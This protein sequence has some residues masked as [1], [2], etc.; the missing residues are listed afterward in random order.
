MWVVHNGI[1]ENHKELRKKLEAAGHTFVSSTDTE[2]LTHLVEE[3]LKTEKD[4]EKAAVAALKEVKGTY[5]V[6]IQYRQDP[7]RI[8][9]ARMGA[10]VVLGLGEHENFIASDASPI[11]RHTRQIVFLE[12]GEVA[13]ITPEGH[14]IRKLEGEL[15]DRV[16]E[17]I[18]WNAEAAQRNGYD[19]F[20]LKEIMEEP[21]AVR[22]TSRG[23]IID[24]D[25][26][27]KLGGLESVAERLRDIRR[28]IIVACGT[29]SYAAMAG[30]YMLEENARIPAEVDI[31]S[32]F[33]YR[34]PVIDEGTAVIAVSQSGET[35][36]T[37]EAVREGKRR[38]AL[39]LGI[40]NTVGSTI[41]RETDAGIYLHAGP[42]IS[43]A[44]TKAYV[45]QLTALALLTLFLGRQRGM[46]VARGK[47]IAQALREL[48]GKIE[49]VLKRSDEIRKVAKKYANTRDFLF[50]G[51]KYN[52]RLHS[53]VHSNSKRHR[54]STPKAAEQGR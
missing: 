29:A 27:A 40:V 28:I 23:R 17:Q 12:D 48:P 20:M 49:E 37:L 22:N 44:S 21:D 16:A 36:D 3:H 10:P 43:V 30:E 7:A 46:S 32:E 1:V 4:F 13:V 39:T 52:L 41:A 34:T 18:D 31:G 14:T 53:K 35:A 50:M 54:T 15:V 19:H 26:L 8:I 2:V 11:L 42:E 25:G 6:A 51:R 5:G 24:S 33:R 38:G 9:G 47:E 45:S